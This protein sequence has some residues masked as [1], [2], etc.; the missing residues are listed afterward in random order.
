MSNSVTR[1]ENISVKRSG[2]CHRKHVC[3]EKF[4]EMSCQHEEA[5]LLQ[6]HHI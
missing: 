5:R 4:L 1:N 3:F 2:V 6:Q